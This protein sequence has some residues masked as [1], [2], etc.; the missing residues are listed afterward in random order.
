MQAQHLAH[1]AA[2]RFGAIPPRKAIELYCSFRMR[3][4]QLVSTHLRSETIEEIDQSFEVVV[5]NALTREISVI[6][7]KFQKSSSFGKKHL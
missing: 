7:R 5:H 4:A 1:V 6:A 2:L 3:A